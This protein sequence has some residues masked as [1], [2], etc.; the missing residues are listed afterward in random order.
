MCHCVTNV[1]ESTTRFILLR[2]TRVSVASE[3]S[4]NGLFKALDVICHL[5]EDHAHVRL[6]LEGEWQISRG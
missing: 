2:Q 5:L 6:D 1:T 4:R 3:L